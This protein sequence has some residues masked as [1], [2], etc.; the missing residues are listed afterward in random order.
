M[1]TFKKFINTKIDQSD[2]DP[3]S[4]QVFEKIN[5]SAFPDTDSISQM[6]NYI[7]LK[8]DHKQTAKFQ[9]LLMFWLSL[10][11]T[12]VANNQMIYLQQVNEI[13]DLQNSDPAYTHN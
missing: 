10:S 1:L 5:D 4:A 12:D 2:V 6:A 3:V 9:Q 13:V 11:G 8:L 7:Y